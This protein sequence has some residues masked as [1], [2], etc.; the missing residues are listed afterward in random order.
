MFHKEDTESSVLFSNAGGVQ[1]AL[2][3]T[4]AGAMQT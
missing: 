3:G 4:A 2:H 1:W